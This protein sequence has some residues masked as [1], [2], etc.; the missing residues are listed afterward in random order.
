[1]RGKRMLAARD[2][3]RH[4]HVKQPLAH[5]VTARH[6]AQHMPQRRRPSAADAHLAQRAVQAVEMPV[7]VDHAAAFEMND[8]VDAIGELI[9]TVLDVHGGFE[10]AEGNVR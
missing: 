8:L 10:T 2:A 1:M 9:A 6:L 3:A 5:P 7:L 4:L